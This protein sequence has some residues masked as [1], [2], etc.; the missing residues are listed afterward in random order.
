MSIS[1]QECSPEAFAELIKNVK[2]EI[3]KVII[4]QEDLID[5]TLQC[6]FCHNHALL[7][8]VPGLAKTLLV[9]TIAKVLQLDS[10]RVQFTPDL[11]PSDVTGSEII[12]EDPETGKK[13]FVFHH[14]PIFANL[15]LADEIN[16]T[17]PRTQSA[18]LEAM[19]E[20]QVTTGN[21][22][23][24]LDEPFFVLATQNPI[25]Q[26]GTYRLP[27]AQLDRFMY[28]IKV[29]YPEPADEIQIMKRTT[30]G[31]QEEPQVVMSKEQVLQY[32]AVLRDILVRDDLYDYILKI[33]HGTRVST[34]YASEHAKQWIAWGA[35]PRACQNLILGAKARALFKGRKH[36]I[37]ED[38]QAVVKPVLRH[39]VL[40]NYAAVSEGL[41][42]D[43][44]V[45]R[46]LE[47][48]PTP[49]EKFVKA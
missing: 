29:D 10:S 3:G 24:K 37:T 19:Q 30:G 23:H 48:I 43:T 7:E 16:R 39:R 35:G 44:I 9:T 14:G 4:G 46:I 31:V 11:M 45:D 38:V 1:T 49:S 36:V 42:S 2:T 5:E 34:I 8:G 17:P 20:R 33:V 18:L 12:Q 22:K 27:E 41:T 26:D 21:H 13:E 32:Q 40:V 47:D 25:E 15:V 6:L 28:L